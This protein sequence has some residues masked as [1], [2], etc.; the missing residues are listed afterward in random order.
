MVGES[1]LVACGFEHVGDLV[2]ETA[3]VPV[4]QP[5]CSQTRSVWYRSEFDAS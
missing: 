4:A 2:D 5:E 1:G 3:F